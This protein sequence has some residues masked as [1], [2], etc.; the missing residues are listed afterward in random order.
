MQ[1][2]GC[3]LS[4]RERP[5]GQTP[6][7]VLHLQGL[8]RPA[9][10]QPLLQA[11]L[12]ASAAAEG[13]LQADCVDFNYSCCEALTA[14][15]VANCAAVA[16]L[17]A[18]WL[19]FN[20]G[21]EAHTAPALEALAALLPQARALR[22]LRMRCC[23][24]VPLGATRAGLPACVTQLES[25]TSLSLPSCA[26]HDLPEGPYLAGEPRLLCLHPLKLLGFVLLRHAVRAVLIRL[27]R[28]AFQPCSAATMLPTPTAAGCG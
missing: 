24:A 6:W 27:G 5:H 7:R 10:L 4:L 9:A 26:L 18:L 1:L 25:L 8:R 11:L 28:A 3:E 2:S 15:A 23:R 21:P 19:A 12:P 20:P 14:E 13:R 22:N 16:Q 17:P